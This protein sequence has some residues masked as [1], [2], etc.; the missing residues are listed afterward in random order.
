MPLLLL[1]CCTCAPSSANSV[2]LIET[3]SASI[4]TTLQ[5]PEPVLQDICSSLSHLFFFDI[6]KNSLLPFYNM[7]IPRHPAF[8]SR[9]HVSL[10]TC[11]IYAIVNLLYKNT[12]SFQINM[13][14]P[15]ISINII[16]LVAL[17]RLPFSMAPKT[18]LRNIRSGTQDAPQNSLRWRFSSFSN[19]LCLFLT[20]CGSHECLNV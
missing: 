3:T 9:Y 14:T 11:L 5:K 10:Q 17:C 1:Q 19:V 15:S 12:N 7:S 2:I 13:P 16:L 18:N 20:T 8:A 4:I 6:R